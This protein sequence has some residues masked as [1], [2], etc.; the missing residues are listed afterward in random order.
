M[1]WVGSGEGSKSG[2]SMEED[3]MEQEVYGEKVSMYVMHIPC[4]CVKGAC[5]EFG[6]MSLDRNQFVGDQY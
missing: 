6:G 4:G 3:F 2:S 1:E 5:D